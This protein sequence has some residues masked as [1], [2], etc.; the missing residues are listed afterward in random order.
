MEKKVVSLENF[1]NDKPVEG[2]M[3]PQEEDFSFEEV[4]R[5]NMEKKQR[6]SQ[7][8]IKSN[9]SVIRSYRLKQ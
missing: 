4:M 3:E 1:R 2:D 9:S 6:L 8:R 7:E 5:R